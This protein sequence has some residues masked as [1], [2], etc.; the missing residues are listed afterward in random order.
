LARHPACNSLA[1]RCFGSIAPRP[2]REFTRCISGQSRLPRNSTDEALF[3]IPTRKTKRREATPY[4]RR[5]LV[6]LLIFAL[7]HEVSSDCILYP[8]EVIGVTYFTG[9]YLSILSVSPRNNRNEYSMIIQKRNYQPFSTLTQCR[10]QRP[11]VSYG[12]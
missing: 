2:L 7:S 8:V 12:S 11:A 3:E 6:F 9:I 4:S 1:Q 10:F 5:V